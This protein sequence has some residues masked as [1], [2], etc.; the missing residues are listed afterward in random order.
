MARRSRDIFS[1][2]ANPYEP[3]LN[4]L[5]RYVDG[6]RVVSRGELELFESADLAGIR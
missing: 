6:F 2:T 4:F 1:V 3:L 5:G